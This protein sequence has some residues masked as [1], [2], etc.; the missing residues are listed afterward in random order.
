[1]D[2]STPMCT[3][4]LP[5]SYSLERK[6]IGK[7]KKGRGGAGEMEKIEKKEAQCEKLLWTVLYASDKAG[8]SG[9]ISEFE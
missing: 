3:G 1:M 8:F 2:G 9:V 4:F 6:S 5:R 7:R